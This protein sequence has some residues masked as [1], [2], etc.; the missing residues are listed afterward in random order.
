MRKKQL[1]YLFL[2]PL[3]LTACGS[4][5]KATTAGS[6]KDATYR[7]LFYTGEHRLLDNNTYQLDSISED[8]S[9]GYTMQNP[10]MVGGEYES[11]AL[12]EK[13]FL[14]SLLGPNGET[15]TFNR[16]GSCCH[17]LSPN[18]FMGGGLLDRYEVK[19]DG[20]GK[21]V[22]LYINMYDRG[23]LKAPKGFTIKR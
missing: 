9:Y 23:V 19:I 8:D 6:S 12:N 10:V 4:S 16:L 22:I 5:K 18:G 14:N 17:F 7:H 13:R 21:S 2:A 15:I 1:V 3:L 20:T 11:G